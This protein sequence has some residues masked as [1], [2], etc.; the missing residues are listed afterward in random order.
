GR[1]PGAREAC[2]KWEGSMWPPAEAGSARGRRRGRAWRARGAA[3]AGSR[4]PRR[5]LRGS[6][7]HRH[8]VDQILD[9]EYGAGRPARRDARV[10]LRAPPVVRAVAVEQPL[11]VRVDHRFD[12]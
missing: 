12:Q 4:P 2:W 9:L 8:E 6:P 10:S 1:G 7:R 5:D 3:L 11:L